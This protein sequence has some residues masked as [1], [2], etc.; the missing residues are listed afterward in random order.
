M[1][2]SAMGGAYLDPEDVHPGVVNNAA[3]V[4]AVG[5]PVPVGDAGDGVVAGTGVGVGTQVSSD[6]I[7]RL[8]ISGCGKHAAGL[9]DEDG[10]DVSAVANGVEVTEGVVHAEPQAGALIALR[11]GKV[12]PSDCIVSLPLYYDQLQEAVSL[13]YVP[14]VSSPCGLAV[15]VCIGQCLGRLSERDLERHI[16]CLRR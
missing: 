4:A 6:V 10:E 2:T 12:M 1:G 3:C 16:P 15:S 13:K 7:H 8:Y 5:V 14:K 11:M 9:A